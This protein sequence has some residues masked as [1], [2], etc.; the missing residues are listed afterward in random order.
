[1]GRSEKQK[2]GKKRDERKNRRRKT[3]HSKGKIGRYQ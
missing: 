2:T 1:M 3:F